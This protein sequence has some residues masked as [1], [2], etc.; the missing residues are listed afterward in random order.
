LVVTPRIPQSPRRTAF[1]LV[2]HTAFYPGKTVV[3]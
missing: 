3:G 2:F 1:F